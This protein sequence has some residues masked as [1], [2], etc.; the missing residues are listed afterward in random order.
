MQVAWRG[1]A[2]CLLQCNLPRC[3]V[4]QILTA[5]DVAYTLHGVVHNN[6]KLVG[7]ETICPLNHKIAYLTSNV[8]QLLT[9]ATVGPRCC[10]IAR[11]EAPCAP[12]TPLEPVAAG[13]GVHEFRMTLSF[14]P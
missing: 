3:V 13:S 2:Q 11:K 8:L 4:G 1:K 6:G 9:Q 14:Q 10:R 7:K 5:H 12:G